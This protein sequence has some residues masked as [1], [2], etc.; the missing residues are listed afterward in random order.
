[1]K[2]HAFIHLEISIEASNG[3]GNI[4]LT[5]RNGY[6]SLVHCLHTPQST[7]IQILKKCEACMFVHTTLRGSLVSKTSYSVAASLHL[8]YE[9]IQPRFAT[10]QYKRKS[11]LLGLEF[12]ALEA[13]HTHRVLAKLSLELVVADLEEIMSARIG[14][15]YKKGNEDIHRQDQYRPH[16]WRLHTRSHTSPILC[17]TETRVLRLSY[18]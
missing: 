18:K 6:S 12:Q 13:P 17:R 5:N 10:I 8:K 4:S 16:R 11:P 1:M 3:L 9:N 14:V 2:I 15:Q 7:G